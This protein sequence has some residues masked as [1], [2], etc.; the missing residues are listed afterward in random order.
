MTRLS[1]FAALLLGLIPAV[2]TAQNRWF[3]EPLSSRIANYSIDV[4][5]DEA[6]HMIHGSETLVWRNTSDDI[7]RELRFH[8]YLN[9]FRNTESTFF[10]ERRRPAE[11]RENNGWGWIDVSSMTTGRGEDLTDSIQF[12]QPDDANPHDRTVIRVPL[13]FP[14]AP[15]QSITLHIDFRAKLPRIVART[16]YYQNFY[17]VG[18]WFPKIGVYEPSR[19]TA[20]GR[21]GWNC[22]QFHATTEFYSDFGVYDV[23]IT[24]PQP[25]RV[26]AT[27]T[28]GP[29]RLNQDG[30]KTVAFH[31]EDVHDFAWTAFPRYADLSEKWKHVTI[32]VLMQPQ[33]AGQ[34]QRYFQSAKAALEYFDSHVGHYPYPILT[35]VDP[36]FG[37][38]SAGGMEYPTLI[39]AG[40]LWGVGPALRY[41]ELVTIHEFGHQYW[42]GMSA[43][44]EFEEPWLDE[45]VNQYY[46]VRIMD[47]LYGSSQ[48]ILDVAGIRIG[49]GELTRASYVGMP[50]P[51]IAA[52]TL[53]G[54]NFPSGS[55][56]RLVYDKTAVVLA[57][58]EGMV[59][60]ACMDSA[61][62][63]FFRRWKFKHPTG[64]DLVDVFNEIIPSVHG[65]TFGE[66]LDWF[67]R[68]TLYGTAVCD[69]ELSFISS[70]QIT[71]PEGVFDTLSEQ[72]HSSPTVNGPLYEST[73]TVSNLGDC[74]LPVSV[75]VRFSN[76]EEVRESWDG[77]ASTTR[78]I[79]RMPSRVT[80]AII[81]P[82]NR[83]PLDINRINNSK[84]LDPPRAP[85]WNS[86]MQILFW[87]QTLLQFFAIAG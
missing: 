77:M 17:M 38:L 58:L 7:I 56:G 28:P 70:H 2:T 26:G 19:G 87:V 65:S 85:A 67:F 21:W 86:S 53:P 80:L 6:N 32:R 35:I 57:T 54:W 30:T 37:A 61:M 18:Q 45:G 4:S 16:G 43:S 76:G 55:Y 51:R 1:G 74:R 42:Y 27:G 5:L 68:Q 8:L 75:L 22:H 12:V 40:S 23:R 64:K 50:N 29:E 78:F 72:A 31:A 11:L 20:N 15:G 83:I 48:S 47:A 62:R 69:F 39:T 79:Y 3:S 49:D 10:R 73:V 13:R 44:N 33:R 66:S 52:L 60:Q 34:A 24:V 36:A 46:E 84:T 41:A 71:A 9:A 59:G 14:L 63:T 81:D 82:E 25:F